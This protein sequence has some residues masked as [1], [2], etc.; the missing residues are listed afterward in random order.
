MVIKLVRV[1]MFA[2]LLLDKAILCPDFYTIYCNGSDK[3]K[4][5]NNIEFCSCVNMKL[6]THLYRK[7]HCGPSFTLYIKKYGPRCTLTQKVG[8]DSEQFR[9]RLVVSIVDGPGRTHADVSGGIFKR[10]ER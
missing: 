8:D 4:S 5:T 6:A 1:K 9:F 7:K 2:K 3:E 10:V